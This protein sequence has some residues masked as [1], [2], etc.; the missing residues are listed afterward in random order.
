VWPHWRNS[1]GT[2]MGVFTILS[3]AAISQAAWT[4]AA[5]FGVI[6]AFFIFWA[7]RQSGCAVAALA[8]AISE[9]GLDKPTK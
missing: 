3:L 4:A 5:I 8:K 6:A 2:A 9:S 1:A 7:L